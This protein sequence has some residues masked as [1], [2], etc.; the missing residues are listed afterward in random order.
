MDNYIEHEV[1]DFELIRNSY[2]FEQFIEKQLPTLEPQSKKL[3]EDMKKLA[4]KKLRISI[5][6]IWK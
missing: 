3:Y 5:L 2:P 6:F 4:Y 1:E